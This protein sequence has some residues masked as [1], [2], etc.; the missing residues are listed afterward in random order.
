MRWEYEFN[1]KAPKERSRNFNFV[2]I[3][4]RGIRGFSPNKLAAEQTFFEER[5]KWRSNAL[6]A[7]SPTP[8][9]KRRLGRSGTLLN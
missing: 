2:E 9:S 8:P 4:F 6:L 7:T 3:S 1:K 5:K